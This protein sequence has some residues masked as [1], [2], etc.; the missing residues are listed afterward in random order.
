MK[1]L[2]YYCILVLC[3]GETLAFNGEDSWFGE[4]LLPN[5]NAD[6][7]FDVINRTIN[8]NPPEVDKLI[9]DNEINVY[10]NF[11][12]CC[13]SSNRAVSIKIDDERV[14]EIVENATIELD[15]L[16]TA[17][18]ESVA[19]GG[20]R[21]RGKRL[22][23]AYLSFYLHE[24]GIEVDEEND[25]LVYDEYRVVVLRE[26]QLRDD[27]YRYGIITF[28]CIIYFGFGCQINLSTI[29]TICKKPIA[30]AIGV[31]CQ[32]VVMPLVSKILCVFFINVIIFYF[33][34]IYFDS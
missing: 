13:A 12:P 4:F 20:F 1:R 30:P 23:L 10:F 24:A 26:R 5:I 25:E 21:V 17:F 18:N 32:F 8:F 6:D 9:E 27:I 2:I 3:L 31:T 7:N 22:G 29:W 28:A 11:T 33:L 19:S 34:F 14:A 16:V 15:D